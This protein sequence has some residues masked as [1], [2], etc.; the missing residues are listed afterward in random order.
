ML[1]AI[2]LDGMWNKSLA[3]VRSLGRK[4]IKVTVGETTRLA[5]ALFSK[6]CQRRLIYPCPE[7]Y[8]K[9]FLNVIEEE[10]MKTSYQVLLPMELSTQL[11]LTSHRER[12][13]KYTS[14]PFAPAEIARKL[15]DKAFVYKVAN[16]MGI[17]TPETICVKDL[18]EL[19]G[20][21]RRVRF[22]VVIKPRNSSGSRG[23]VYVEQP[24]LLIENYKMVHR[25]Y[26]YPLVQERI[27][28]GGDAI[29]VCLLLNYHS[30]TRASFAYKRLRE[31]PV[32]GGP[33]TLR[34]SI[35]NDKLVKQS[36]VMLEELGW[37]GVAHVEFKVDPRDGIAKLLEVNPRFWGSL[38]LAIDAGVDFPYLLF[39][40]AT[41]GDIEPCN[42]YRE[43]VL[44][45]WLLPGDLLHFLHNPNRFRLKPGFFDFSIKDDIII[46]EDLMPLWGRLLSVFAFLFNKNYRKILKRR[47]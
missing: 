45:R 47:V 17:E 7:T 9:Q 28:S 4:G 16:H 20:V 22:P 19:K 15:H 1:R 33:S 46:K 42:E 3:A 35:K 26:P 23:I 11:L 25:H 12:I 2:V 44:S 21:H 14:L 40:L 30:Q 29:G 5:T 18:S 32:E 37:I 39:R 31:Y 36:S 8:P 41:E 13:E 38:Q 6:Y 27:P 43:G 10:L 24:E 34:M